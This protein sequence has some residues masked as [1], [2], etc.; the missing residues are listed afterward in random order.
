MRIECFPGMS[1]W[2]CLAVPR[3]IAGR[4]RIAAS[5]DESKDLQTLSLP[6]VPVK[7]EMTPRNEVES[8]LW[9]LYPCR[10]Q[11]SLQASAQIFAF[12]LGMLFNSLVALHLN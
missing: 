7:I 5:G 10:K 2:K 8:N 11:T 1:C 4:S 3:E 6:S 9:L 12:D